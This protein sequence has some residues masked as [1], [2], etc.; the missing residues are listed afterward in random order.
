MS[1]PD[2]LKS[3]RNVGNAYIEMRRK[4]AEL[5]QASVAPVEAEVETKHVADVAD[6]KVE[7]TEVNEDVAPSTGGANAFRAGPK[8]MPRKIKA[9]TAIAKAKS[10]SQ[11]YVKSGD[12]VGEDEASKTKKKD[13]IVI[14]PDLKEDG[15]TDVSS[16]IRKCKTIAEDAQ[17][18][19]TALQAMDKEGDLPT[20][21][22]NKMAVSANSLNSMRDYIKNPS[23]MSEE[24]LTEKP[25]GWIAIYNG[26]SLEIK[27]D[28]DAKDLFTAKQFAIN[29]FKVPKS[30]Q[31]LLAIAPA[32]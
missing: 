21:W 30:K 14:N 31:G 23:D 6:A 3:M 7:A 9:D 28:K 8:L 24:T 26:K 27:I 16:A 12:D 19:M 11:K 4:E 32:Y 25:A 1:N 20:W 5:A 10:A 29:H 2:T 18:I 15:H 22:T 17:E 13:K